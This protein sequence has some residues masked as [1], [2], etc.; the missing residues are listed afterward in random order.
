MIKNPPANAGDTGSV[1]GLG[2]FPGNPLQ[3]SCPENPVDRNLVGYSLQDCSQTRLSTH[4][5]L[6][7]VLSTRA[8][9][10]TQSSV[11]E[12]GCS[13]HSC[14]WA[15]VLLSL[16]K[17]RNTAPCYTMDEPWRHYAQFN[18]LGTKRQTLCDCTQISRIVRQR[19]G[20]CQADQGLGR[21]TAELLRNG[22]RVSVWK[23][24]RVLEVA[25]RCWL[26]NSVNTVNT[27]ELYP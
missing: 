17:E 22:Y 26:Y 1:P 9:R 13:S 6:T 24:D 11:P 10:Q 7:P 3:C 14:M 4:A 20:R 25:G 2:R 15:A 23:G 21:S 12:N 8:R 27:T 19:A 18:K 16:Q 5:A